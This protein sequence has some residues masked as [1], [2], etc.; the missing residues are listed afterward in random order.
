MNISP[1][2]HRIRFNVLLTPDDAERFNAHCERHGFKKSTL[3]ARLVRDHL[4]REYGK[5]PK[6]ARRKATGKEHAA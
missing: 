3:I 5:K 2:Q 4:D 1:S 6:K